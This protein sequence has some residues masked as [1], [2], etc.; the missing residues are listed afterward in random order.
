MMKRNCK[1]ALV[2]LMSCLP[3]LKLM[4]LNS[5]SGRMRDELN[6]KQLFDL[7]FK[8]YLLKY[9]NFF[10]GVLGFWGFGVLGLGFRV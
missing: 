1:Q 7:R 2:T 5:L 6:N 8:F 3:L 10:L 9:S 4:P